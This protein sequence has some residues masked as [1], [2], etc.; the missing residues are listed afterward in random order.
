MSDVEI[1]GAIEQDDECTPRTLSTETKEKLNFIVNN[2]VIGVVKGINEETIDKYCNFIERNFPVDATDWPNLKSEMKAASKQG[3]KIF[4]KCSR[5]KITGYKKMDNIK[6][7]AFVKQQNGNKSL[8]KEIDGEVKDYNDDSDVDFNLDDHL[9]TPMFD[10]CV[11]RVEVRKLRKKDISSRVLVGYTEVPIKD[12]PSTAIESYYELQ[13][14]GAEGF[15]KISLPS[16]D[17]LGHLVL[18]L[19]RDENEEDPN[20]SVPNILKQYF[21]KKLETIF[22][23]SQT[24]L[25]TGNLIKYQLC[26]NQNSN[27]N[28][29]TNQVAYQKLLTEDGV[30][31]K[32]ETNQVSYNIDCVL[33]NRI[34]LGVESR[35]RSISPGTNSFLTP[36][37]QKRASSLSPSQ[38]M[39]SLMTSTRRE[40]MGS[41]SS[42]ISP[43]NTPNKKKSSNMLSGIL[44][45]TIGSIGEDLNK[46]FGSIGE[47]I[48]NLVSPSEK[49]TIRTIPINEIVQSL[50]QQ[51]ICNHT[52]PDKESISW[53]T[54]L[55]PISDVKFS[56]E[57]LTIIYENA[58]IE[59][60]KSFENDCWDGS[61]PDTITTLLSM[62]KSIVAANRKEINLSK[63]EAY[64]K[65]HRI[66]CFTDS[67][68]KK[69]IETILKSDASSENLK[70]YVE[71]SLKFIQSYRHESK[72]PKIS[73]VLANLR[74][75]L[76]QD[77]EISFKIKLSVETS[78]T[79]LFKTWQKDI[80]GSIKEKAPSSPNTSAQICR[81][82]L[83]IHVFPET[84]VGYKKYQ[85][86]FSGILDYQQVIGARLIDLC[87]DI[88]KNNMPESEKRVLLKYDENSPR[89]KNLLLIYET[90]CAFK[91]I[92]DN[93]HQ[94]YPDWLFDMYKQYPDMWVELALYKAETQVDN[95]LRH[96]RENEDK[97]NKIESESSQKT[98]RFSR[99]DSVD[100]ITN[101][102]LVSF[103]GIA[104]TSWKFR[105]ELNWPEL[106]VSLSTGL[107]LI[108][109]M[110]QLETRILNL[111]ES[112]HLKDEEYDV[113]ELSRTIKLLDGLLRRHHLTVNE[114]A[115]LHSKI[116]SDD[117]MNE[118]DQEYFKT[119]MTQC[120]EVIQKVK[121]KTKDEILKKIDLYCEGR[122][123]K[124][125]R[126]IQSKKL[127][128]A[129]E[130]DEDC[131]MFC[132]DKELGLMYKNIQE[133]YHSDVMIAL[134][135]VMEQELEIQFKDRKQ[136]NLSK[137]KPSRFAHFKVAL[138]IIMDVKQGLYE[139]GIISDLSMDTLSTCKSFLDI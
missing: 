107:K 43:E 106:D 18:N 85:D 10:D 46:T 2:S 12:I 21:L 77:H 119:K 41:N 130:D 112:I 58:I 13:K 6:I 122:R 29:Q 32:N 68:L 86:M 88:M 108:E 94:S 124:L 99:E 54:K 62:V 105:E 125:K 56:S 126:Y 4:V 73:A 47:D 1:L 133:K 89:V 11:I 129:D 80:A 14:E 67:I 93:L 60:I 114:I 91:R 81:D 39:I 49:P 75:I 78:V 40:S 120:Y 7:V 30:Y 100:D 57:E 16:S 50:D 82:I 27:P 118:I 87:K 76:N 51:K 48:T 138:P 26:I 72:K 3:P 22:S 69:H 135:K 20:M 116:A 98:S 42:L 63:A 44:N 35:R 53:D 139:K 34:E 61:F 74:Q 70:K 37:S 45:K 38:S 96:V 104:E 52:L 9:M 103:Y 84:Q 17:S 111:F 65:A 23:T 110:A 5:G 123:P 36:G 132:M 66:S 131:L 71:K 15:R 28:R 19:S 33:T 121:D 113:I 59:S 137:N 136:R 117:E 101:D 95:L 97:F 79:N 24:T 83:N 102:T 31:Q 92:F 128:N 109:G 115:A 8:D 90:F 64:M 25:P 134:W 127:V 55:E